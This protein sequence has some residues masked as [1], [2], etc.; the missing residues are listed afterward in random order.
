MHHCTLSNDHFNG[1]S[2]LVCEENIRLMFT[3]LE[4]STLPVVRANG[5]IALGDL[6]VR[7]PNILEP[8]TQNL[9]ARLVKQTHWGAAVLQRCDVLD[10]LSSGGRRGRRLISVIALFIYFVTPPGGCVVNEVFSPCLYTLSRR[11]LIIPLTPPPPPALAAWCF[12]VLY[13]RATQALSLSRCSTE[14]HDGKSLLFPST[15]LFSFFSFF[16]HQ[17]WRRRWQ[18]KFDKCGPLWPELIAQCEF[19]SSGPRYLWTV[20]VVQWTIIENG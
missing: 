4:R 7:F 12:R 11:H 13:L 18:V 20:G 1:V 2:P 8:W 19:P 6:T 5:I 10:W 9:Y 16:L 3:V 15:L 14:P 17:K